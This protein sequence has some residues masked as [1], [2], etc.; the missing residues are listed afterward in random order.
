MRRGQCCGEEHITVK[1]N[2]QDSEDWEPDP[3][4]GYLFRGFRK[5]SYNETP[6]ESRNMKELSEENIS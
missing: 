4:Q 2:K 6:V 3:S 1:E 5:D